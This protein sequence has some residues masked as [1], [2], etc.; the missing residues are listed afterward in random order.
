MSTLGWISD[1]SFR[2]GAFAAVLA[3][4][5]TL[6]AV[7]PRRVRVLS[8]MGR[9]LTNLSIIGLGSLTVRAMAILASWIAVPLVAISA[10]VFAKTHNIG[11]FN[12]IDLPE[13]LEVLVAVVVLDFA[14]WLQH[15]ISHVWPPLWRLHQVHHADR[16]F[17]ATTGLRFHPIEIGLSMLYKVVWV[18]LLGVPAAA[19]LIFEVVLNASAMFNHANW[20]LPA[21]G[22]RVIRKLFVTPDMHRVHHSVHRNEHDTNYGFCLS[23]WDRMFGTYTAQPKDGHESMAIGLATFQSDRPASLL[24]CLGLPFIRRSPPPVHGKQ[25]PDK[26]S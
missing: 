6:E 12:A 14:V 9:W 1:T 11:L 25:T 23:I 4:M 13:W 26:H 21:R 17:D 20:A 8:R 5:L 15:L 7:A 22:D 18:V 19:V 2:F 16:D 10:A 3:L 24:W